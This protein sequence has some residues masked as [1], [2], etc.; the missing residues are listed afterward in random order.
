MTIFNLSDQCPHGI[1][2]SLIWLIKI[3]FLPKRKGMVNYGRKKL[4]FPLPIHTTVIQETEEQSLYLTFGRHDIKKVFLKNTG[5]WS[6][7]EQLGG[8]HII[9]HDDG[10]L[11]LTIQKCSH[12]LSLMK[13][14]FTARQAGLNEV[15][16][17]TSF[18]LQSERLR[19]AS[20]PPTYVTLRNR[21]MSAQQ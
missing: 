7:Q 14:I 12:S 20:S 6:Y 4:F 19:F 17:N 8:F 21:G 18:A 1:L 9:N 15:K 16:L 10:K 3:I 5:D 11:L 13:F 2:D